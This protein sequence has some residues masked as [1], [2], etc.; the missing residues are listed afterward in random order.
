MV[1]ISQLKFRKYLDDR[2]NPVDAAAIN[3][4]PSKHSLPAQLVD[5]ECDV[6]MINRQQGIIVGEIKSVGEDS[7]SSS[8][9][10]DPQNST[11][12]SQPSDP[13]NSMIVKR[14]ERAMKQVNNQEMALRHLVSDLNIKVTR[15]LMFPNLDSAQMLQ[16]LSNTGV[17]QVSAF[18]PIFLPIFFYQDS[19]YWHVLIHL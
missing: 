17:E 7:T 15:T 14:V 9:P 19:R 4:L 1:V 18:M 8:Q 12:S 6:L 13:Q 11:P 2:T 5:G 16:A 3:R 10:S